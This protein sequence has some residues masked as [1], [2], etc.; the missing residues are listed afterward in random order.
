[1]GGKNCRFLDD[2]ICEWPLSL[3]L[4]ILFS[5]PVHPF[6][7][8][9]TSFSPHLQ[10]LFSLLYICFFNISSSSCC[11]LCL[12]IIII[13]IYHDLLSYIAIVIYSQEILRNI[14]EQEKRFTKMEYIEVIKLHYRSNK[15]NIKKYEKAFQKQ[16]NQHLVK[17]NEILE[18]QEASSEV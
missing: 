1:M 4:Y 16:L 10:I 3:Y 8:T 11:P 5:T 14:V 17:L 12:I 2:V 13:I 18:N 6:V 15:K 9:C 7:A